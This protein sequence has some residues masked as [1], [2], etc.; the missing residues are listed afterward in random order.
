MIQLIV[1]I[2]ISLGINTNQGNLTV[3]Q[4]NTN[5][6]TVLNNPTGTTITVSS[7]GGTEESGWGTN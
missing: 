6:T 1:A 5:S 4:Q 3:I 7:T 2:L